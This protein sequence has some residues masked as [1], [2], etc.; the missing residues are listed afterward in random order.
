MTCR[1]SRLYRLQAPAG[2]EKEPNYPSK[3]LYIVPT[4]ENGMN[5]RGFEIS[6][7][8]LVV[9][10]LS[11]VI[12][13]G[14]LYMVKQYFTF[15]SKVQGQ[16]DA[17]TQRQI[18][19]KLIQGTEPVI[20]PINKKTA[21]GGEA[22]T[23]GLG[24]L[25]TLGSMHTFGMDVKFAGAYLR[26]SEQPITGDSTPENDYINN[27]WIMSEYENFELGPNARKVIPVTIRVDNRMN[28]Q[29]TTKA[30]TI[31][32]FNVCVYKE[33]NTANRQQFNCGPRTYDEVYKP[34]Q[35]IIDN[36]I[37]GRKIRKILVEV[38]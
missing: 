16:I 11:V 12:F 4:G 8:M 38:E 21:R 20:I 13:A 34:D 10:I 1:I 18:N 7:T 36:L 15:A 33:A 6:A 37:L 9:L 35:Q 2:Q 5:R 17:D 25:N 3:R 24:V 28:A 29:G 23:F 32:V 26:D 31:Y 22:I 14:G 27:N 30:G 19:A